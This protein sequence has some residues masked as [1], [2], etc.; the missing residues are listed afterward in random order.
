M[1][2]IDDHATRRFGHMVHCLGAVLTLGTAVA[3]F[4]IACAPAMEANERTWARILEL[5][6]SLLEAPAVAQQHA[7]LSRRLQQ[8][9]QQLADIRRRVPQEAQEAEFLA[10]LTSLAEDVGLVVTNLSPGAPQRKAG[11]S[12]MDISVSG[13]ARYEGLCRFVDGIRKFPRL[14]QVV[15][16]DVRHDPSGQGSYPVTV[17]TAIFFDLGLDRDD[18]E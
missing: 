3:V 10:D 11:Y 15:G 6:Q 1:L 9:E 12:Q 7:E 14:V 2:H 18:Q 4:A 8:M 5:K 16:L 17:T 13:I